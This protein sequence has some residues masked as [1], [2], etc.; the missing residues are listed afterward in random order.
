MTEQVALGVAARLDAGAA[1]TPTTPAAAFADAVAEGPAAGDDEVSVHAAAPDARRARAAR[2]ATVRRRPPVVVV[3][4][5]NVPLPGGCG[6]C[7]V[8]RVGRKVPARPDSLLLDLRGVALGEPAV[9]GARTDEW[10]LR[11]HG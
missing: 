1:R 10:A 4:G 7:V 6:V 5:M 11:D 8:G 3:L 2:T 9:S